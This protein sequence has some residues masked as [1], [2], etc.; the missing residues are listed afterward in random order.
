MPS[1][2]WQLAFRRRA[3]GLEWEDMQAMC[4]GKRR[5]WFI[6]R[7]VGWKV[8]RVRGGELERGD[9]GASRQWAVTLC[10]AVPL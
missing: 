4:F 2:K 8:V 9:D 7:I 3:Y 5:V 10:I 6:T 1:W